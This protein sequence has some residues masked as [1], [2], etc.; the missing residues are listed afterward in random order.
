MQVDDGLG[1]GACGSLGVLDD[2][3]VFALISMPFLKL[4]GVRSL[5]IFICLPC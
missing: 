1:R 3:R 2:S 5:L 4:I